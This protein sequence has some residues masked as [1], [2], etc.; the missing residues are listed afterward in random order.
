MN[1]LLL[2]LAFFSLSFNCII[3]R[4]IIIDKSGSGFNKSFEIH[5]RTLFTRT[6]KLVCEDALSNE[7]SWITTP[8][9]PQGDANFIEK[10]VVDKIKNDSLIGAIQLGKVLLNWNAKD[11]SHFYFTA[12]W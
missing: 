3:K 9:T 1:K 6:H 11:S 10:I 7:C 12:V 5:E 4:E 2:I 8:S